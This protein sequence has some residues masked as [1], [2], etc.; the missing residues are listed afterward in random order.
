[1]NVRDVMTSRPISISP[2]QTLDQALSLMN[3]K[4]VRRLPVIDEGNLAGIITKSD[5][6]SAVGG[7]STKDLAKKLKEIKVSE[8]MSADVLTV[9]EY[10]TIENCAL[11]MLNNK[12]SGLPVVDEDGEV[13]GIVTE[14][15]IFRTF[16][17]IMGLHEGGARI[18][19]KI[20]SPE[21]LIDL[22]TRKM[23]NVAIR[24]LV[25]Y[26]NKRDNDWSVI[27]RVRGKS[28]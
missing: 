10:D 2:N 20:D 19:F 1:M 15:D 3:K 9:S 12:V 13:T 28:K 25:C 26:K 17:N 7:G 21:H 22:L 23:K 27:V 8:V 11:I 6:Y 18:V 5:I 4:N 14:T 16:V 24:S